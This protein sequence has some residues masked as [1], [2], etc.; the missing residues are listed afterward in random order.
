MTNRTRNLFR[1]FIGLTAVAGLSLGIAGCGSEPA[2]PPAAP[3]A[4]KAPP[5]PPPAPPAPKV[6]PIS[7]LM[8]QYGIDPRVNLSE[9]LAPDNDE[10]RIAVL[11]FFDGFAKGDAARLTDVLRGPLGFDGFVVGDWNGH[12]QVPGSSNTDAAAAILAG[13]DMVMVPHDW[14]ALLQT[15]LAQVREGVIPMARIDEAVTRILR[16]KMRAG[17]MGPFKNKG[18]PSSRPW[19]GRPLASAEHRAVAREAVRKSLVLL[20][21]TGVLPLKK[22]AKV[23]VTGRG[24]HDIG[25]QSGGWT[26][27][28]QGTETSREDFPQATTIYEAFAQVCDATLGGPASPDFDAIVAVIGE[29]PYAEGVGDVTHVHHASHHPQDQALLDQLRQQAPGVPV[30]SVLLTGRPLDCNGELNRSDAFVVAWLPGGEGAGLTDVLFGD[31][32]FTGCLSFAWPLGEKSL[33]CGYGLETGQRDAL[34]VLP[35]QARRGRDSTP[36]FER[37][38]F[39]GNFVLAPQGV[40]VETVDGRLQES[41][42]RLSWN[43][44]GEVAFE[45]DAAVEANTLV[46]ELRGEG[47]LTVCGS[48]VTLSADWQ[49]VRVPFV[50]SAFALRSAGSTV[51]EFER[52]TLE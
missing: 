48:A 44:P 45:R 19:A 21:D 16:V 36:V 33:P 23:L 10:G 40:R 39:R 31:V 13:V 17:L 42:R 28:W 1:E 2:P 15:T 52:I 49:E 34:G 20:K 3:V 47:K 29:A 41:A 9:D 50:A 43:G 12:A 25:L 35:E 51:A 32:P 8:A 30:V 18:C 4:K 27:T 37:G 6:T 7:E 46:L 5:P 24:A 26:L 22:G 14:E 38:A 11:R